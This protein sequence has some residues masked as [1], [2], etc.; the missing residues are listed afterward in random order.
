MRPIRRSLTLFALL[1]AFAVAQTDPV[2]LF[3]R[4]GPEAEGL[5]AVAETYEAETG[6]E[7]ELM[8]I[9]RSGYFST[10]TTQLVS[11]TDEFDLVATNSAYV[12]SLA[13][14]GATAPLDTCLAEADEG[15]DLDDILFTYGYEGQTYSIPFDVSTHFLYYRTDLIEQAPETW[16]EYREVAEQWTES[17]NPDS[18]TRYGAALTALPGP[19]LPKTFYNVMWS[20]GGFIID[21]EGNVGV[22]T[23]GAVAAA[24]YYRSL[25][26]AGVLTLDIISW[27]FPNVLDAL[28]TGLV[29]MASPYW[30]AAYPQIK[31]SESPFK[32][33]IGIAPVPGVRRDDGSVD[34]TPFQHGWA[35]VMNEDSERKQAACEFLRFATGPEG[36]LIYAQNGGTPARR[37][38][39]SNPDL[40]PREYYELVLTS[41]EQSR[42]E[43][44]VP[45]Y[46]DMHEVMNQALS[47]VL[48]TQ[49]DTAEILERAADRIRDLQ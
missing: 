37:S 6:N 15:Y 4:T 41:L 32:D 7:V 43:P 13:A 46:L 45:F 38:V 9:G 27:G 17:L 35:F 31:A 10:M 49:Q 48:T 29:A 14:A 28:N 25:V 16:E 44:A 5:R 18:P 26:D 1:F 30:N 2:V 21:E 3:V 36:M 33:Q 22:D 42:D 47:D 34:R 20:M 19:E 12:A 24:E 8:E 40:E 11:G 23:D 39:L